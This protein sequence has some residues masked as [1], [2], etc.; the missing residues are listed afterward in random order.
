MFLQERESSCRDDVGDAADT[1]PSQSNAAV[2]QLKG[3]TVEMVRAVDSSHSTVAFAQSTDAD[4]SF[5]RYDDDK[6]VDGVESPASEDPAVEGL[7]HY[8]DE[9][10]IWDTAFTDL[11]SREHPTDRG[12]FS[13]DF[14]DNKTKQ[15]IVDYGTCRPSGPFPKDETQENRS[16]SDSYYY[17]VSKAGMSIQVAW[18]AYSL[19]LDCAYCEPCWLFADRSDPHYHPAWST[20][21]RKWKELSQKIKVHASSNTHLQSCI[22][23]EQWKR[24]RT[25]T[26]CVA[27]QLHSE[28][29]FGRRS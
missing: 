17:T 18:L 12:H 14:D 7:D 4:Q 8:I 3:A 1:R 16:F 28:K 9:S 25:V 23:Y 10:E 13:V 2:D 27:K 20:G 21:V 24:H 26:D 19:V 5:S 11:I 15:F 22:V 6:P 29:Q